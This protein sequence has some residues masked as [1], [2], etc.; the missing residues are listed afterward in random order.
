MEN[1]NSIPKYLIRLVRS[2]PVQVLRMPLYYL[3]MLVRILG[4]VR[5]VAPE[6]AVAEP[7]A[8]TREGIKEGYGL[9]NSTLEALERFAHAPVLTSHW[10]T[11]KCFS[12]DLLAVGAVALLT[13]VGLHL[14]AATIPGRWLSSGI[15]LLILGALFL[16]GKKRVSEFNDHRNLREI[17]RA[18]RDVFGVRYVVFGHSHDPDVYR[19]S[20]KGDHCYFNV[21]TWIPGTGEGQFIYLQILRDS[22]GSSAHLMRWNR[23]RQEPEEVDPA[24]YTQGRS[25]RAAMLAGETSGVLRGTAPAP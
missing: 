16:L 4:K 10:R 18:I 20:T 24:S 5:R 22:E 21:G 6:P 7:E 11:V 17:A 3:E 1:V 9:S 23:K 13:G 12:I 25:E 8:K 19:L 14:G 2:N 15:M